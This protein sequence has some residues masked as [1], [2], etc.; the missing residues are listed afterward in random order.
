MKRRSRLAWYCCMR[1]L[2]TEVRVQTHRFRAILGLGKADVK[3]RGQT[4]DSRLHLILHIDTPTPAADNEAR[5][6][7]PC[8]NGATEG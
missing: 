5:F 4:Q 2:V 1:V 6:E 8:H 3:R 7:S